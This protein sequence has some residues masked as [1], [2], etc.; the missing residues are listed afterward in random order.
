MP[1]SGAVWKLRR[2]TSGLISDKQ[3][4]MLLDIR[5]LSKPTLSPMS[6]SKRSVI[7]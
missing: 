6:S 4:Q 5:S 7:P 3:A 2:R 1:N